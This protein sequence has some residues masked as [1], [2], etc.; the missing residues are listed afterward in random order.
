MFHFLG[1]RYQKLTSQIDIFS[2]ARSLWTKYRSELYLTPD[3][4][5]GTNFLRSLTPG[6]TLLNVAYENLHICFL[7]T[8]E[9][10]N[11]SD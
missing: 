2:K 10:I 8:P 5:A 1:A 11:C 6:I 9:N 7:K 4:S 3:T